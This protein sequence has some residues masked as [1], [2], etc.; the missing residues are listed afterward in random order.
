MKKIGAAMLVVLQVM[1]SDVV[2]DRETGFMWQDSSTIVSKDYKSAKRYC[3]SLRLGG[4]S[5]W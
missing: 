2:V 4:Y 5:D 3:S 1:A